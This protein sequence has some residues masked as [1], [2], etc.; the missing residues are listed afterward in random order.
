MRGNRAKRQ[1][2]NWGVYVLERH[3][4]KKK[5]R[6]EF[7]GVA[8]NGRSHDLSLKKSDSGRDSKKSRGAD[9]T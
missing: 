7:K 6:K 8:M 5:M 1:H 4:E 3:T 2:G 9:G